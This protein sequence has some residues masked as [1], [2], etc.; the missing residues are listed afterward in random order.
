MI[1]F[2]P[3]NLFH[4][5][6]NTLKKNGRRSAFFVRREILPGKGLAWHNELEEAIHVCFPNSVESS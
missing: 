2:L 5:V 3:Y 4:K 6:A 1:A